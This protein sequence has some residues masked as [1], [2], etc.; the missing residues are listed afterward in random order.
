MPEVPH[1]GEKI[2]DSDLKAIVVWGLYVASLLFGLTAIVGLVLAYV[3]RTETPLTS[4]YRKHFD[5]QIRLFWR[6]F[7]VIAIALVGY[8]ILL[9][10][11]AVT[12]S[13]SFGAEG[14]VALFTFALV[15]VVIVVF[16]YFIVMSVIGFLKA[17]GNRPY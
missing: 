16:I 8:F 1:T 9:I 14:P 15:I 4:I 6:T 11:S 3:W 17:V 7:A 5:E 2:G 10:S 12:L 13:R